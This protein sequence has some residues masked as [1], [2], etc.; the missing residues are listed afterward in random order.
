MMDGGFKGE[1][2][3]FSLMLFYVS[4]SAFF[5]HEFFLLFHSPPLLQL[6]DR[7]GRSGVPDNL[8]LGKN[9]G[10]D[11]S[12][13]ESQKEHDEGVGE[14]RF[15]ESFIVQFGAALLEH[16]VEHCIQIT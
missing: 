13:G 16:C 14:Y 5:A 1:S 2:H 8:E 15:T 9:L 3:I 7:S 10:K 11:R 6:R 4:V 12:D